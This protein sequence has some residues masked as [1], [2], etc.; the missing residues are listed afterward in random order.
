MRGAFLRGGE[1]NNVVNIEPK[2]QTVTYKRHR[3]VVQYLPDRA[4][5]L[6]SFTYT[7]ATPFS[8]TATSYTRALED[9]KKLIDKLEAS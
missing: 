8:N 9:A 1:V 3:I 5:W 4:E 7:K 6:W 2:K